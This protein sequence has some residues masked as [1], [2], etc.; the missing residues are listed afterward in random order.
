MNHFERTECIVE[1]NPQSLTVE[2]N[3]F[4]FE[5]GNRITDPKITWTHVVSGGRITFIAYITFTTY[6]G[7]FEQ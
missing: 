3:R 5:N 1:G 7:A 4:I 2:V 6:E